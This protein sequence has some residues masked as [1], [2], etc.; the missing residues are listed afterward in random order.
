MR[1]AK[2]ETT[3]GQAPTSLLQEYTASAEQIL[4]FNL[5]HTYFM[6]VKKCGQTFRQ[7]DEVYSKR[8]AHAQTASSAMPQESLAI[9][10]AVAGAIK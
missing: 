6:T 5:V 7:T 8:I 10:F 9:V 2:K 1:R 3:S 4:Q